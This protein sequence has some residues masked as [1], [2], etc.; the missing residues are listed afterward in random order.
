MSGVWQWPDLKKALLEDGI[1]A[2][3]LALPPSQCLNAVMTVAD[4]GDPS[5]V[6][7]EWWIFKLD[8][9]IQVTIAVFRRTVS[10]DRAKCFNDI[11]EII[12][13]RRTSQDSLA[14]FF[15]SVAAGF[16]AGVVPFGFD[17]ESTI[18]TLNIKLGMLIRM[19]NLKSARSLF[20]GCALKA[21]HHCGYS[22]YGHLEVVAGATCIARRRTAQC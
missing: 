6:G 21:G 8:I 22:W 9:G 12:F 20:F 17:N 4:T 3:I 1:L 5:W 16:S 10:S 2:S 18:G 13:L 7:Q 11:H 14:Y 19:T 15:R